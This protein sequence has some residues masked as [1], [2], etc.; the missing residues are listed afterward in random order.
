MKNFKFTKGNINGVFIT[1]LKQIKDERG[2]I[3]P[4]IRSDSK[5][6]DNFGE[7]YF[8]TIFHNSV[9]AWRNH[10]KAILNYVC[11]KGK[12]RL[13]L[14]DDRK[15]S[16]SFGKFNEYILSPN[17]YFLITIPPQIWNGFIGL[18]KKESIIANLI[19]IPH[20]ETEMIRKNSDD[21]Y[22]S[23]DWKN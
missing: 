4:M 3:F 23:Y 13:V 22:F 16:S 2:S 5:L 20:D 7:I 15:D 6:F 19:N 11:I 14:F 12:I 17:D 8:S 9:K 1:K 10:K 18:D 21:K